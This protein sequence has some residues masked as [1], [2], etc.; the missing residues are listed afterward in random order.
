MV[1]YPSILKL[2]QEDINRQLYEMIIKLQKENAGDSSEITSIK[3]DIKDIN[4]AIGKDD[5]ATT[6]KGRL[7]ALEHPAQAGGGGGAA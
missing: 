6:I 5:E 7:Y 3:S 1:N 2:P 4:D